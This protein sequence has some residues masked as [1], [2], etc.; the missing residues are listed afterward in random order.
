M[1]S[2]DIFR[3]AADLLLLET[4][5]W[6]GGGKWAI[7]RL[8]ESNHEIA[9]GLVAWAADPMRDSDSLIDLAHEVLDLSGGYVQE[10]FTRGRVT[11]TA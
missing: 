10:G 9:T 2:A 1:L 6:L 11:G 8:A 7:R 5:S 4:G 3:D